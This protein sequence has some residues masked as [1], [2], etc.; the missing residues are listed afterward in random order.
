VKFNLKGLG[1][2]LLRFDPAICSCR[3]RLNRVWVDKGEAETRIRDITHPMPLVEA[4]IEE[5]Y[6]F[7]SEDPQYLIKLTDSDVELICIE[8]ELA[9]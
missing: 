9:V 8:G 3:C 2:T 7:C 1:A 4:E 5:W 6:E